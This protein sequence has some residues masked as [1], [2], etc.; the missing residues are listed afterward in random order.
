[1]KVCT[2][3]GGKHYAKGKCKIHYKMPSQ[4]NP[5]EINKISDSKKKTDKIY[6]GLRRLYLENHPLCEA[7]LPGCIITATEVHHKA[8]RNDNTL[9]V[10]TWLPVCRSCHRWIEEH[11]TEAKEKGF[12][13]NRL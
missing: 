5:K 7:T 8:G 10:E 13:T 4:M 2:E 3:C 1:M 6:M 11:P 12:S 9:R